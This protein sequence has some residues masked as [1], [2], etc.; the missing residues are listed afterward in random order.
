MDRVSA[1]DPPADKTFA[2]AVARNAFKLMACKDE[3]EVARL[4]TD[5]R[6]RKALQDQFTGD[7]RLKLQMA[8]P[9]L[10]KRAPETGHLQNRTIGPW[11]LR[12]MGLLAKFRGCAAAVSTSSAGP[13]DAGWNAR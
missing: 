9:I 1:A 4:Y 13:R 10:S 2:K 12:A 11:M 8:P 5:G 3:Y 6:F 7:F